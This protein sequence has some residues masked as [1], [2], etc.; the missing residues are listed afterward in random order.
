MTPRISSTV[1]LRLVMPLTLLLGLTPGPV[2][3][4]E[5][6]ADQPASRVA[7]AKSVTGVI[8]RRE[9]EGKPWHLVKEGETLHS[10]DLLLGMS[11]AALDSA[12]GAVRLT[13]RTDLSGSSPFPI[14]ESAVV[15]NEAK[16]FD[17]DVT[18]DRG[19][20]DLANRKDKGEAKVR[21]RIQS[22]AGGELVLGPG[23]AVTL[24][25]YS[26]WMPGVHFTLEPKPGHAPAMAAVFLVLKGEIQLTLDRRQKAMHA[27]PGPAQLYLDSTTGADFTPQKVE[28]LPDWATESP[29]S[30]A[31]KKR[32]ALQDELT[33]LAASKGI[34]GALEELVGSNDPDKRRLAVFGMGALD[35]LKGLA[36]ALS[37]AKHKDVWDNGV[38]ALRH[39]IGRGPGQDMKLYDGLIKEGKF[40][41]VE[42]ET[43]LELLHSFGEDQVARPDLYEAL[44]DF[45]EHDRLAIRGLAHWHLY[46]LAPAGQKI[47]Y[48]PLDSKEARAKAVADWR[49]LIPKGKL[50]PKAKPDGK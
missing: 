21:G 35:D 12:N 6:K 2:Q 28:K 43:A 10:G 5:Q 40:S 16:G 7:V 1:A 37:N 31:A 44:I 25:M 48:N 36:N 3:A 50:P 13:F 29:N 22:R 27:P 33:K 46:R 41:K 45:L 8:L 17:L 4:A 32:K 14:I 15:L 47:G 38:L 20:I 9:A 11:G 23:A 26:R 19:R 24:E 42:A 18:L 30:E 39:W 49:K 34:T